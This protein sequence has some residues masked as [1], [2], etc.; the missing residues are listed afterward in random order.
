MTYRPDLQQAR[1][2]YKKNELDIIRTRNGLLPRLDLFI[3]LSRTTYAQSLRASVPD[4]HSP[5]YDVSV[6]ITFDFPVPNQQ[7]RARLARTKYSR[8]Q[9]AL[10]LKNMERLVQWDVRSAYIEVLRSRQQINAT[11]V[12]RALQ[13]K[14]LQAEL[15]KF[16]VGKSTNFLVLQAQRDFTASSLNEARAMVSY[17]EAL[18]NLYLME[19]TL[20]ERRG[21]DSFTT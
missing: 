5:F 1:L 14:K 11:Q 16:S 4:P 10:A 20:L 13:E 19:G 18:V 2:N 8:E 12:A 15:E 7:A 21:I 9:L 17:L 3:N 6:G